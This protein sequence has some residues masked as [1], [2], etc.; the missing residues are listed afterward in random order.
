MKKSILLFLISGFY[1]CVFAQ[2]TM[3][4]ETWTTMNNGTIAVPEEP[5]LWIT[6][7]ELVSVISPGNTVSA[8]KVTG[9]EAHGGTY[10]MK[11]VTV[12]VSNDPTGGLLPN[13]IGIATTG[14]IQIS[15]LKLIN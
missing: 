4:F 11:I 15:P 3:D 5:T 9:A 7:N 6:G 14:K 12:A 13:P 1:A 10:A 2:T 8:F